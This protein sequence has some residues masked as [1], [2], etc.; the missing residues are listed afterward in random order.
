[1]NG[2]AF[3]FHFCTNNRNMKNAALLLLSICLLSLPAFAQG[4]TQTI[5]G[6]IIDEVSK[7][8]LPGVIVTVTTTNPVKGA[9]TDLDGNFKIT[10]VPLGRHTLEIKFLGYEPRKMENIMI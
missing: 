9:S 6:Q 4:G 8:P 2:S 1:M 3:L 5:R 10:D 7:S